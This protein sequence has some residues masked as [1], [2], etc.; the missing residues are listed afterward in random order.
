MNTRTLL[1]GLGIGIGLSAQLF[2]QAEDRIIPAYKTTT[3]PTIDGAISPGEWD[4]AGP[5]IFVNQDSP[6]VGL[7]LGIAEDVYGGDADLSYSFRAMWEEPWML[8]VLVEITDDIAMEEDPVNLWERDQVEL[9]LDGDDLL[10]SDDDVTFQWWDN[11]EPFGKFG[12]SR[13]TTFE[14]NLARMTDVQDDIYVDDE[15][16]FVN[17]A[18][19][20]DETG[21]NAN[22]QVEYA[23]SI[24]PMYLLGTFDEDTATSEAG[25]IVAD[26]TV[27]K[28]QIALSDD[29]NYSDGT[30]ERS[31]T[32]A[33]LALPDWRAHLAIRRSAFLGSV[34]RHDQGRLRWQWRTRQCGYRRTHVP[35]SRRPES[36]GL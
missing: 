10:G 36:S 9:F 16:N 32:L 35:V 21:E 30:T 33:Y 19:V 7:G 1:L 17:V 28:A 25:K 3:S 23:I 12:A 20:A 34:Y 6:N 24:E 4:A 26:N 8:Y 11:A 18:T 2:A 15:V 31:H 29:D 13:Y 5:P 14:G 27:I 22:W